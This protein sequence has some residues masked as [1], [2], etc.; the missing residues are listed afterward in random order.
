MIIHFISVH[1]SI[2]ECLP[3]TD[4]KTWVVSNFV[5]TT[6]ERV[7]K[8]IE[9]RDSLS[10]F[11][12]LSYSLL[13][14][15]FNIFL[16]ILFSHAIAWTVN[17][18]YIK[19]WSHDR[20]QNRAFQNYYTLTLTETRKNEDC[21]FTQKSCYKLHLLPFALLRLYSFKEASRHQIPS[22][23]ILGKRWPF[24]FMKLIFFPKLWRNI[25]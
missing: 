11:L 8:W 1:H 17:Q 20:K 21:I 5:R 15:L 12:P 18:V 13:R 25:Q 2:F 16:F 6:K 4:W 19:S 3:H 14:F 23:S 10:K 24:F 7:Q 9:L 22:S